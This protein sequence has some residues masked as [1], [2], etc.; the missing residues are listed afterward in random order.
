MQPPALALAALGAAAA[1]A[2]SRA[3][4]AAPYAASLEFRLHLLL[5]MLAYSLFTI[6]ILHAVLMAVAERRLHRK[7][8]GGAAAAR[9]RRC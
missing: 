2:V 8:G 5:A 1:G 6:A 7:D 9:C 3:A 4:S